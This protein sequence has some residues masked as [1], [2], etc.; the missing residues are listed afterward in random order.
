MLVGK[1]RVVTDFTL[2]IAYSVSTSMFTYRPVPVV[3]LLYS[4]SPMIYVGS[5]S[6]MSL[7][8]SLKNTISLWTLEE[9]MDA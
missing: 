1:C 5:Q 8:L 6:L 9:T 7:S 3:R 4:A 2:K